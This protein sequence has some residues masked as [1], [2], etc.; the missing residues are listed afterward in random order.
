[1]SEAYATQRKGMS[2]YKFV[3]S[4]LSFFEK[5]TKSII[6]VGSSSID[7]LSHLN[8][9]YKARL[10]TFKLKDIKGVESIQA[11]WLEYECKKYF[12]IIL[13]MQVL[14]H[15][16][17]DKIQAFAQKLLF[18]GKINIVSVPYRWKS[19]Y[20]TWH[21][22]DPVDEDKLYS[23]F[24]RSYDMSFYVKDKHDSRLIAIYFSDHS[25]FQSLFYDLFAHVE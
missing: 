17:D 10:D 14:E 13:C 1:M 24:Q 16:D 25:V 9:P 23:W 2:Y 22:Q 18:S 8:I 20:C 12:D 15:I 6:D 21:V 3:R 5:N 4:L 11:D 19:G 7:N